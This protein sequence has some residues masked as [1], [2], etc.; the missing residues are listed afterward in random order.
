MIDGAITLFVYLGPEAIRER[1]RAE[2]MGTAI[3]SEEQLRQ[4][5]LGDSV[6]LR[7]GATFV[8]TADGTLRLAA[9]R[10]EHV[11]CAG[12][13]AVRSAG[14]MQFFVDRKERVRVVEVSNLSTGYAPDV[15]SFA[16]VKRA[17]DAA[18]V[19]APATWTAAFVLRKCG[20]CGQVSVIK[21]NVY[22]CAVCSQSLPT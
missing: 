18:G 22:E 9:R 8:V 5:L 1:V 15:T 2:S 11:A 6:R 17:L 13:E 4:W 3:A 16:E 21:D 10:S 14:E 12:G 20:Q 7:E 19:A